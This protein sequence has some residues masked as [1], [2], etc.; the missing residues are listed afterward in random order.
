MRVIAKLL[1]EL[2]EEEYARY[3]KT[4]LNSEHRL[5]SAAALNALTKTAARFESK[6][7]ISLE[8]FEAIHD[9]SF[10]RENEAIEKIKSQEVMVVA[11]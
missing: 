9:T 5:G 11:P 8:E 2:T 1:L 3:K 7:L 6:G 4:C 10:G